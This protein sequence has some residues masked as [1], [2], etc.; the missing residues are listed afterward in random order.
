MAT[1]ALVYSG[2]PHIK[3]FGGTVNAPVQILD[4]SP[5]TTLSDVETACTISP[6]IADAADLHPRRRS[7]ADSKMTHR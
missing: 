6:T 5:D 3:T 4:Q 2:P 7:T 1:T